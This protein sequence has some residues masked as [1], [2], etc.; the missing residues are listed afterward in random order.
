MH[1]SG[2]ILMLV[3]A[4]LALLALDVAM[5]AQGDAVAEPEGEPPYLVPQNVLR[6]RR[7]EQLARAESLQGLPARDA[8]E[9]RRALRSLADGSSRVLFH[10]I[11]LL[12][13]L[14]STQLA[15]VYGYRGD[16][17]TRA[18]LRGTQVEAAA[19][20]AVQALRARALPGGPAPDAMPPGWR[21]GPEENARLHARIQA[22]GE[23]NAP[24]YEQDGVLLLGGAAGA[25][26]R[27][28]RM[29]PKE[30]LLCLSRLQAES[31]EPARER[32]AARLA[33]HAELMGRHLAASEAGWRRLEARCQALEAAGLLP[34]LAPAGRDA[35]EIPYPE[36]VTRLRRLTR[37]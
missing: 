35:S 19:E 20:D 25:S 36:L 9:L 33:A 26:I 13:A 24:R 32:Q 16:P 12:E 2:R 23:E 30:L 27:L 8:V 34:R 18:L 31:D 7:F 10:E 4:L 28:L 15:R 37:S 6:L 5:A 1:A 3:M 11:R 21:L 29:T 17:M 14:E 22:M